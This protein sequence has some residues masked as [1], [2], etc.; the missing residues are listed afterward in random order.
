LQDT[1]AWLIR[2]H[3]DLRG[4]DVDLEAAPPLLSDA[5]FHCQQAA[6]KAMKGFLAW[7]DQPFRKTHDLG[8][9]GILC[10]AVDVTLEPVLRKAAPLTEYAWRYRYPGDPLEPPIDEVRRALAVAREVVASILARVP[11]QTHP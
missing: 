5:T 11:A 4:A 9:L 3:Q 6:E 1:R 8:E 10:V 2:A 7:H